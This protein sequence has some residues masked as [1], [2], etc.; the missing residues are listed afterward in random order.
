MI[1][2]VLKSW[3]LH[4]FFNGKLWGSSP[5]KS[6]KYI[7]TAAITTTTNTRSEREEPKEKKRE[8][9]K[10]N[11]TKLKRDRRGVKQERKRK[12]AVQAIQQKE[13]T[14]KERHGELP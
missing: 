10:R 8:P 11:Y 9:K 14:K 13:A 4:L 6:S 12:K 2:K 5:Q 1:S 3:V 7:K